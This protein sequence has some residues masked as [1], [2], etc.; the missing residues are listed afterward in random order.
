MILSNP[1]WFIEA[2]L[3]PN[4]FPCGKNSFLSGVERYPAQG[5]GNKKKVSVP[6]YHWQ[7]MCG[8]VLP[9]GVKILLDLSKE[10]APPYPPLPP[11][12]VPPPARGRAAEDA[13][14]AED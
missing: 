4:S 2:K 8:P 3:F 1:C 11:P 9:V 14:E 7:G 13:S 5:Q 12:D 6:I 10:L